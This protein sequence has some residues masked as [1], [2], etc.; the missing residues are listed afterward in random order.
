VEGRHGQDFMSCSRNKHTGVTE[1]TS[2]PE[3]GSY[4]ICQ[5][6]FNTW[7]KQIME[8][9]VRRFMVQVFETCTAV[10]LR[11]PVLE[12]VVLCDWVIGA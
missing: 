7:H 1:A 4:I 11:S 5:N 12:D 2:C 9:R 6:S 8:A 3:D 10:Q